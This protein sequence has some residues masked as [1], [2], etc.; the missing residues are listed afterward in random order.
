MNNGMFDAQYLEVSVAY[1]GCDDKG[2]ANML[3]AAQISHATL[4]SFL[5]YA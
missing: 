2:L 4:F 1:Y 3:Y 5:F